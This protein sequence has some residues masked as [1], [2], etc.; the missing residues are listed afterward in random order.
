MSDYETA[1]D[2]RVQAIETSLAET[3][4]VGAKIKAN[5]DAIAV[6]NGTEAGSVSKAVAD[7]KATIDAYTVNSKAI[8]GNPV[9]D[10]TDIKLGTYTSVDNSINITATTTIAD[11]IKA[12]EDAWTWGE[13]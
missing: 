9:L 6:L 1:N 4:T 12:L 13:A 10:A 5:A 7:A 2:T 3:G 11:A 8:S